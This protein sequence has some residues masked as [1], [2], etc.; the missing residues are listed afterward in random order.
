MVIS[1]RRKRGK[2]KKRFLD[3]MKMDLDFVGVAEEDAEVGVR[4]FAVA[5]S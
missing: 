3:V 1:E 4:I 2:L 5:N